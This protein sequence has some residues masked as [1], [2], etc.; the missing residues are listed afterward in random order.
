MRL[1]RRLLAL[2]LVFGLAA[3]PVAARL[4]AK[5]QPYAATQMVKT[6]AMPDCHGMKM[7][8]PETKQSGHKNC[9]GCDKDKPCAANACELQCYKIVA[10]LSDFGQ[11]ATRP[12]QLFATARPAATAPFVLAPPPPPPRA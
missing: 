11:E 12:V 8:A 6:V 5:S 1:L 2:L 3:T 9:P 10:A 7:P 4:V